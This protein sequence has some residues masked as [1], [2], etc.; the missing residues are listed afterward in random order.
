MNTTDTLLLQMNG[1]MVSG[2]QMKVSMAF[3]QPVFEG[4]T[5]DPSTSSWASIGGCIAARCSDNVPLH[6]LRWLLFGHV[7]SFMCHIGVNE[8]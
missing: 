5:Q 4:N 3:R 7:Q 6:G 8:C 1:S 2:V